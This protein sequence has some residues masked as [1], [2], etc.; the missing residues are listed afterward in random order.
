MALH[1]SV[2]NIHMLAEDVAVCES[3]ELSNAVRV[4]SNPI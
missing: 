1:E 2:A 3:E 4:S